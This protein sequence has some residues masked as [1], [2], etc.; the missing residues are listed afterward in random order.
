M[1]RR[2]FLQN[3]LGLAGYL[4]CSRLPGFASDKEG[5]FRIKPDSQGYKLFDSRGNVFYSLGLNHFDQAALLRENPDDVWFTR[6]SN[7]KEKWLKEGVRKD[8][9]D[10]GF[11]TV[12]W[13]ADAVVGTHDV[14]Y[15]SDEFEF[16]DYQAIGLPYCHRLPFAEIH[17]Y[18]SEHRWPDFFSEGFEDWCDYVARLQCVR[19]RDDPKLIGYFYAD[20]P[21]WIH[22]R[23][24]AAWKGPI[25]D[26]KDAATPSG[27]KE[28]HRIA[29]QYYR[30]TH[31]AIRRYDPNHLILGDRYDAWRPWTPVVFKAAA[32]YIDVYSIQCFG[33][34]ERV[35]DRLLEM[36]THFNKPM[37]LADTGAQHFCECSGTYEHDVGHYKKLLKVLDQLPTNIGM[38]FCGSYIKNGVRAYGLKNRN[39]EV[40]SP[41]ASEL[42]SLNQSFLK[43]MYN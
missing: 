13:T 38:H 10:W 39:D 20:C 32:P 2:D 37:L 15:H 19:F 7:S 24:E 25:M 1:N 18:D 43:R 16:E 23:G 31:E 11:N 14:R 33:E 36:G 30:V 5:F 40:I 8:M 17:H 3:S 22:T 35:R 42:H 6:Y 28:L 27:E 26:P 41:L 9:L 4:G 29:T 12:G 34:P 21:A